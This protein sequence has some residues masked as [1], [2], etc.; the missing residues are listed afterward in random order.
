MI[1]AFQCMDCLLQVTEVLTGSS[2]READ[3]VLPVEAD[4]VV[5]H[6]P[7]NVQQFRRKS[8]HHWEVSGNSMVVDL[9]NLFI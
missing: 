3:C 1:L 4:E 6:L 9:L 2:M 7:E 8:G 5:L